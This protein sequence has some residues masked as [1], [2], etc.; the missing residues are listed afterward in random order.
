MA[1]ACRLFAL[2]LF[3]LLSE[4]VL[5]LC[6]TCMGC[7]GV[8]CVAPCAAYIFPD[9]Q[10]WGW[11]SYYCLGCELVISGVAAAVQFHL[12]LGFFSMVLRPV[13]V[14]IRVCCQSI[15]IAAHWVVVRRGGVAGF[16]S[17]LMV[18]AKAVGL[19]RVGR[20][21]WRQGRQTCACCTA[22]K[23]GWHE[24]DFLCGCQGLLTPFLGCQMC[25]L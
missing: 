16:L 7:W 8:R 17:E 25:L 20:V 23:R 3:E 21:S 22:L 9:F 2:H 18:A 11:Q 4:E 5:M 1:V 13:Q 10:G 12:R 6:E 14:L 24:V 19:P 15:R